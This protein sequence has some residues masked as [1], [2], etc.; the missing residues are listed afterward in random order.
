M[1]DNVDLNPASGGATIATDEVAGAH[2][3]RIKLQI[4]ADGSAADVHSGNPL[5][6]TGTVAATLSEPISVDDNGSSLTVDNAALS[7]VG[8]GTEATAQRVTIASDSTGVLS[9]DDNGSTLSVDDGAGS[10][11]VDTPQLPAALV[12][13]R[14]DV[15]IG[16]SAT[17]TVDTELPAAAALSDGFANPTA[18][19]VGAF[20]MAWDPTAGSWRRNA[21]CVNDSPITGLGPSLIARMR[22]TLGNL[23]STV[24]DAVTVTATN[25]GALFAQLSDGTTIVRSGNGVASGALRVTIADDSTGIINTELPAAAALADATANPTTPLVGAALELFNGTTWDRARGDTTNGLDVDVT[26]VP[27]PLSTTGGGTQATALRVTVAT[28]STGLLAVKNESGGALAVNDAGGSLT[29]DGSVSATCTG[30]AAHDSAVSGNPVLIGLEARTSN[31]TAV[32]NGD[33]VRAQADSTGRQVTLVG[34]TPEQRGT[35]KVTLA[36][37]SASDV[38]TAP[39]A[40]VRWVVTTIVI[41]NASGTVGTKV[42]IRDGTTVIMQPQAEENG[43]GL[44]LSNPSGIFHGTANTAITARN[45]TTSADVDVFIGGYKEP[46]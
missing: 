17:I 44:T 43:G 12:S 34:S 31:P 24:D 21:T 29:V 25:Q 10:L 40:G 20:A 27:A 37:T 45:V 42:E 41:T 5:P 4:G 6:V 2:V 11:T 22:S 36:N 33:A 7:V 14:L 9:V 1:A 3:Q 15:N 19:A 38:L 39:G 30:A 46:G 32:G 18:P 16:A 26:R 13:G 23:V 8:G 35:G 28:D